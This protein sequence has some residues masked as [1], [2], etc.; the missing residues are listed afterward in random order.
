[1]RLLRKL[2]AVFW[3]PY[4]L[5][6]RHR[7]MLSHFPVI[8]TMTRVLYV[9]TPLVLV[10]WRLGV[11]FARIPHLVERMALA[12]VIGVTVAET[13]HALADCCP[14]RRRRKRKR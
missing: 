1:M 7:T 2:R 6:F 5:C 4:G 8:G 11:D 14:K 13:A 12:T 3:L 9:G 10:A